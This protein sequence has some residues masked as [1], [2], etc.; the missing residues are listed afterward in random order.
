M[1]QTGYKYSIFNK[2]SIRAQPR[3]LSMLQ[4]NILHLRHWCTESFHSGPNNK[5]GRQ[6]GASAGIP[7]VHVTSRGFAVLCSVQIPHLWFL[8]LFFLHYGCPGNYYKIRRGGWLWESGDNRRDF[9]IYFTGVNIAHSISVK[10]VDSMISV[11]Q[12]LVEQA[13]ANLRKCGTFGH[14]ARSNLMPLLIHTGLFY[15]AIWSMLW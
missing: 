2:M 8:F 14:S 15:P 1:V 6:G 9:G 4:I 13:E 3:L 11:Y 12:T 7:V 10:K 5:Y